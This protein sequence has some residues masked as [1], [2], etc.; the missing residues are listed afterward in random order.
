ML[1]LIISLYLCTI[2]NSY[3]L[4]CDVKN[5]I[6][7]TNINELYHKKIIKQTCKYFDIEY[8]EISY[9]YMYK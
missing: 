2:I 4:A 6:V 8:L 9:K 3:Y 7:N 1:Y 5:C